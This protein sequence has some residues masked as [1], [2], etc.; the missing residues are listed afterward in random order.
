ML[1]LAG[2][3]SKTSAGVN[4]LFLRYVDALSIVYVNRELEAVSGSVAV[5][6][7]TPV[8]ALTDCVRFESLKPLE[9]DLFGVTS[10]ESSKIALEVI[11]ALPIYAGCL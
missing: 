8:G 1:V 6:L 2:T 11:L 3:V 5:G 7:A 9:V 10:K 4:S